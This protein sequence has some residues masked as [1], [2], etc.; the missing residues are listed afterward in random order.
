[1]AVIESAYR[2]EESRR[3]W[4]NEDHLFDGPRTNNAE[5]AALIADPDSRFLIATDG[6][7]VVG[8]ALIRNENG[9]AYFGLFAVRPDQ[10]GSGL[11]RTIM[12]EA[13]KAARDLW[14]C[15]AITM[16]VIDLRT[17]LIDYY[18]R[19]GYRLT[20]EQKPFPVDQAAV[21]TR[22]DFHLVVLRK[23]LG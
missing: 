3:G 1:M 22:N 14:R 8:C 2:G 23:D 11:G 6:Q 16:T 7:D 15:S 21:A 12:A 17:D 18:L 20:G 4:T 19:R 5:V 10:Q 13:E 9:N